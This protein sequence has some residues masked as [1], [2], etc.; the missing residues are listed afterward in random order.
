MFFMTGMEDGRLLK[1]N[2]TSAHTQNVAYLSDHGEGIMPSSILWH[3]IFGHVNYD[4]LRLLR[5][6]G[7]SSFLTIPRKVKNC[8]SCILGKHRKNTLIHDSNS[9]ACKKL[10][11]IHSDFCIPMLVPSANGNKYIMYFIDD[12]TRMCWV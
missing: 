6:N 10:E 1:L 2:G 3:V 11:L 8:A 7:V 9:R 4:S 12:Y 5:N